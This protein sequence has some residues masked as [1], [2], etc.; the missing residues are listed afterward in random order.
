[1]TRHLTLYD[2]RDLDLMLAFA[3]AANDEGKLSTEDLGSTLGFDEDL[4]SVGSRM[5]WMRRYGVFDFDEKA[6]LW[7]MTSGGERVLAAR[8]QASHLR[9]LEKV[10][11]EALIDAMAHVTSRY[12]HGDALTATLLRRE[13]QFGTQ[14]GSRRN[15]R[16]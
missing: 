14:P 12:M 13:F 5:S 3:E 4:K 7:R 11:D 1:M 8:K 9:A 15:G 6:R 16:R 2:F 10:P